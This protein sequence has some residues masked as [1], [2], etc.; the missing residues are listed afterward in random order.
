MT[1]AQIE[2]RLELWDGLTGGSATLINLSENHTFR[3]DTPDGGQHILRVHRPGYHTKNAI[4]SELAWLKALRAETDL[5]TITALPGKNGGLV[6]EFSGDNA[7]SPTFAV[8]FV[9]EQG[10][11]PTEADDLQ[12]HFAQLGHMAAIC[13]QHAENWHLPSGFERPTWNA[14]AILDADG[15]WG[16]WRMAPHVTDVTRKIL[17]QL[18]TQL[19]T[20]L[21]TYG[22]G[23]ERF[24]L[25][26]ADM[27]LA[28]LLAH[29]GQTRLI[30][31][32]DCGFGWF[33]YDFAAAISFFEHSPEV[34]ALQAKWLE[35]YRAQR[36]FSKAD[37]DAIASTIMLRRMA[38][39]AWIGSHAE[40]ELARAQA[41]DFALNTAH[42]AE[43]Y[44]TS[45]KS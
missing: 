35:A 28:N 11:E 3:I 43:N 34:P 36:P 44:L 10:S 41:H 29:N 9:F 18:D 38:L 20:D 23:R 30:D 12:E 7:R 27:R 4:Q 32:D 15:L 13:H 5:P 37:E 42:M 1:P 16:D 26:H 24:G 6:Q 14:A 19:R 31:F 21:A 25:I 45:R 8:R 22:Q 17:D 33:A 40:T 2:T 39:L